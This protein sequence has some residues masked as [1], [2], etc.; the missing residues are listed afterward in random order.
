MYQ[1]FKFGI[2]CCYVIDILVSQNPPLLKLPGI[3]TCACLCHAL[4]Q[5]NKM[6]YITM[7]YK[8]FFVID[9]VM[10]IIIYLTK[11]I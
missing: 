10:N 6:C 8:F 11:K 5:V 3:T 7:Y 9:K 1:A 4:I 2:D